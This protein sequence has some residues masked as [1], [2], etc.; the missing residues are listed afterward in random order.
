MLSC[1]KD[2]HIGY[3]V[4]YKLKPLNISKKYETKEVPCLVCKDGVHGSVSVSCFV[5]LS[6]ADIPDIYITHLS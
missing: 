3:N 4:K 1:V 6:G 5:C 2:M